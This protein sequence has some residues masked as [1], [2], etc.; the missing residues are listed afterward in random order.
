M[1]EWYEIL[2][3]TCD[4]VA[5]GKY[6]RTIRTD[7]PVSGP[8]GLCDHYHDTVA[9]ADCCPDALERMPESMRPKTKEERFQEDMEGLVDNAKRLL[10]VPEAQV[11]VITRAADT[12]IRVRRVA[13]DDLGGRD[14]VTGG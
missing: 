13:G 3:I 1:A 6:R 7:D 12:T 14:V 2:Q 10:G 4:G 11:V 9:E 8:F 5:T